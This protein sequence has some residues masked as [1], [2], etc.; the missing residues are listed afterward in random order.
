APGKVRLLVE[1]LDRLGGQRVAARVF[2]TG[3]TNDSIHFEGTTRGEATNED[4]LLPFEVPQGA[5]CLIRAEGGGLEAGREFT[6]GTNTQ[7]AVVISLNDT[8]L[9][10]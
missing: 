1:V 4:D 10:K 3:M 8:T 5:T 6:T 7:A 2:V 9:F